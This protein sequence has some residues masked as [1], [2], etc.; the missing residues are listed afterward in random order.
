MEREYSYDELLKKLE[1]LENELNSLR[2]NDMLTGVYNRTHF[3]EKAHEAFSRTSRYKKELSVLVLDIKD[4]ESVN[5]RYGFDAGDFLLK[6]AA[7]KLQKYTR[8]TDVTGRIG[9]GKFA[10][11]ME[12]TGKASIR[13]AVGRI[14]GFLKTLTLKYEENSIVVSIGLEISSYIASDNSIYELMNRA[15]KIDI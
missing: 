12:N 11:L 15:E 10:V 8:G 14:G 2:I 13:R 6:S 5:K 1:T 7:E 9:G 4:L 3:F